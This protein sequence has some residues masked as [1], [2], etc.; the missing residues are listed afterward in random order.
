[1]YDQPNG[2]VVA[3]VNDRSGATT[4]R[5]ILEVLDTAV[6]ALVEAPFGDEIELR[7]ISLVDP[8]DLSLEIRTQ[9]PMR[10][11]YLLAG[12]DEAA[13]VRWLE[14]IER[15]DD[16]RAQV[17]LTKLTAESPLLRNAARRAGIAVVAVHSEAR[18]D[19][20]FPLVQR[21]LAR[22]TRREQSERDE[23]SPAGAEIDLFSL[24]TVIAH[25]THGMVSIED[26]QSRV[27]AYSPSDESADEL[28]TLSI[29]GRAG[30]R[31]YLRALT[32]WG[33]FSRIRRSDEVVLV[34]AHAEL[35][36]KARMVVGVLD[37]GQDSST[38]PRVLGSIWVQQGDRPFAPGS[39]EVL[40]GG[41]A[42]A[43]RLITRSLDAPSTETVLIQRLL[44]VRGGGVDA[45]SIANALQLPS[46][47][48]AAI[49]GLAL[50]DRKTHWPN[51]F[52]SVLRL[53]AGA[54]RR[55]AVAT[56]CGD[57][58]YVL[59]PGFRSEHSV[60]AW[61]RQLVAQFDARH[62]VRV[63]AAIAIPIADL[64]HVA[65]A[66]AEVDRVLAATTDTTTDDR[67]TTLAESR[68]VVL[69]GEI[70]DLIATHTELHDPRID[71]LTTYDH[72]HSS[73]LRRSVEVYLRA[74]G[75][76]RCAAAALQIHPNTLRYRIR[77]VEEVCGIDLR[78]ASDRLLLE[79][80]LA[81]IRR[82]ADERPGWA[83]R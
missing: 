22:G 21:M 80:Q 45:P 57:H 54:F 66:R 1:M 63:R 10:D 18:W 52:G 74:H 11:V 43:A 69:M 36:T 20:L 46:I 8:S 78:R 9:S 3:E 72:E 12:V 23:S 30:P 75:D 34:P 39:E 60:A 32:E 48:P 2:Q 70:L 37:P 51:D 61:T 42:V 26:D 15:R 62:S 49:I 50:L 71:A 5:E 64:S 76:V 44:G 79:L 27:L 73:D 82:A 4:L 25:N 6:T 77:R 29:L 35:R 19:Q 38:P 31:D 65:A 53:H 58:A 56:I 55:D 83:D 33:V 13:A 41:A 40:R 28:R 14:H 81:V 59:L 68:T 7:S 47:G 16:T 17:V 24:A 67:V